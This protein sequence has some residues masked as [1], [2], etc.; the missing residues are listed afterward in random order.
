MY[1]IKSLLCCLVRSVQHTA[2]KGHSSSTVSQRAISFWYYALFDGVAHVLKRRNISND[3]WQTA[4]ERRRMSSSV[5]VAAS[6]SR[7][8]MP[9]KTKTVHPRKKC[10]AD[11]YSESC[12]RGNTVHAKTRMR[13][14]EAACYAVG[15]HSASSKQRTKNNGAPF[16]V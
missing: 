6:L 10:A 9:K 13:M 14:S 11:L 5:A 2:C 12:R 15:G 16:R 1:K 7:S 8:K 4:A 3:T